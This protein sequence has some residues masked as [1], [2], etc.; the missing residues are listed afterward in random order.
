MFR[1]QVTG[2]LSKPGE[3]QNRIVVET[4]DRVYTR[5]VFNETT[6]QY[7]TVEIGRGWEIVKEIVATDEGLQVWN[8][9]HPQQETA[10]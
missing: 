10:S 7:E 4:R 9:M 1:C 8:E 3:K 6:R 2:R 5:K